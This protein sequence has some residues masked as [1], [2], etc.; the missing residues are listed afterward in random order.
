MTVVDWRGDLC[1]GVKAALT[2]TSCRV[3]TSSPQA[4]ESRGTGLAVLGFGNPGL[5]MAACAVTVRMAMP[6]KSKCICFIFCKT[7]LNG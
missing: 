3:S 4:T 5:A 1:S 6:P 2:V 7:N